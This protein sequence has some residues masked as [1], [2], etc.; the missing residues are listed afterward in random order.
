MK[1]NRIELDPEFAELVKALR[2]IIEIRKWDSQW[3]WGSKRYHGGP[4][5]EKNVAK[6]LTAILQEWK[7]GYPS[8]DIANYVQYANDG[9]F[10]SFHLGR[11]H[12]PEREYPSIMFK[13]M[14]DEGVCSAKLS[15]FYLRS[16]IAFGDEE[17]CKRVLEKMKDYQ[18]DIDEL[19]FYGQHP[20]SFAASKAQPECIRSILEHTSKRDWD[21][22][23]NNQINHPL[24]AL[25]N[26]EVTSTSRLKESFELLI[27][28]GIKIVHHAAHCRYLNPWG[29]DF[30]S[31][32]G[33]ESYPKNYTA[34]KTDAG[35]KLFADFVRAGLNPNIHYPDDEFDGASNYRDMGVKIP[36]KQLKGLLASAQMHSYHE[37]PINR[38][39]GRHEDIEGNKLR[40]DYDKIGG[41]LDTGLRAENLVCRCLS[42]GI[43]GEPMFK[44]I[45]N[46]ENK[47]RAKEGDQELSTEK[48][49]SRLPP[50]VQND[51]ALISIRQAISR[52][53]AAASEGIGKLR[54]AAQKSGKTQSELE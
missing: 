14:L 31:G 36:E 9:N 10:L 13:T 26:A 28:G 5:T 4:I 41:L 33:S 51:E 12:H 42:Y 18:I 43:L 17:L 39:N 29:S 44:A 22:G 37:L 3:H 20:L 46:A 6:R 53:Q 15:F 35:Q 47:R 16:A 49:L 52:A 34:S 48:F 21:I 30:E 23:K 40:P 25:Q 45:L 1:E 54:I 32:Y 7:K 38:H 50:F 19:K 2:L 27:A 11:Q 24:I 8:V